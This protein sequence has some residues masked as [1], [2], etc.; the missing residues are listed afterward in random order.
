MYRPAR[1]E[2][3]SDGDTP[4]LVLDCGGSVSLMDTFVYLGS[5][6]HRDLTENHDADACFNKRGYSCLC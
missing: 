5:L 2:D 4:G 6:L 1:N 3:Y